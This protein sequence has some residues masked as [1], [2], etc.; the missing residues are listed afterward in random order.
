MVYEW[1]ENGRWE[2]I[3]YSSRKVNKRRGGEELQEEEDDKTDNK[4]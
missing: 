2:E 3:Q 1:M 4:T